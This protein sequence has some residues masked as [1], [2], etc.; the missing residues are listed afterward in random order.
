MGRM[1]EHVRTHD[2]EKAQELCNRADEA[3]RQSDIL[4]GLVMLREPLPSQTE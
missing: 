4:R 1:A 3:K 2:K